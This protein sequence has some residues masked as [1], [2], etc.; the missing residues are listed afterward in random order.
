MGGP[1]GGGHRE[2]SAAVDG[3]RAKQSGDAQV[4]PPVMVEK[5]RVNIA[6]GALR[7]AC[8]T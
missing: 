5:E 4:N 8:I 3:K 1:G 7:T 6:T 2:M